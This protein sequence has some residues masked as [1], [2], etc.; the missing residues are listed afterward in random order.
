[1]PISKTAVAA[2]LLNATPQRVYKALTDPAEI[3]KY[4]FGT[5]VKTDWKVGSK[6]TYSG[7]WEGNKYEDKG[8]V[9]E[10]RENELLHTTYFSSMSGQTDNPDNYS[11]VIYKITPVGNQVILTA[12]QDNCRDLQARDHSEQNWNSVLQL[13]KEVVEKS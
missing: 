6:I 7:E 4:L 9:V 13:L 5:D 12:V 1:M 2:V 11:N 8:E 10:V 3:K